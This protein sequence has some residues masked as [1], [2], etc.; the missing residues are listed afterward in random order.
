MST[1]VPCTIKNMQEDR[2]M[3]YQ[4]LISVG[5]GWVLGVMGT[6]G[7]EML[8]RHQLRRGLSKALKSELN[9]LRF[10]IV[11]TVASLRIRRDAVDREVLRWLKGVFDQY[12]VDSSDK[13]IFAI[14]HLLEMEDGEMATLAREAAD[15]ETSLGVKKQ[16]M[17]FFD[18][19]MA[20]LHLFK[21]KL[22]MLLLSIRSRLQMI[23]QEID[24]QR[25]SF[26]QSFDSG[27]SPENWK[28]TEA[29]APASM[30]LI[31]E[32]GTLLVNSIGK[33][34]TLLG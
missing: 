33:A 14:D 5:V 2:V 6:V 8:R 22:R 24:A 25:H 18:S 21:D 17:L 10:R 4:T 12:E 28:R 30:L 11:H 32:Q 29:N 16:A 26:H 13:M 31:E 9:E 27:L 20:N 7:V 1:L 23:N 19:Q 15:T 3:D 34:L